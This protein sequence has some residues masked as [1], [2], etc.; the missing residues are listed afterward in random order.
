MVW[1]AVLDLILEAGTVGAGEFRR[2]DY[3]EMEHTTAIHA[4]AVSRDG[5]HEDYSTPA[6]GLH[7]FDHAFDEDKRCTEVYS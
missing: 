6:L 4:A 5:R 2:D 7:A 1:G 3:G